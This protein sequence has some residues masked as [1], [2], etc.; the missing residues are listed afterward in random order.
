MVENSIELLQSQL[1]WYSY[2]VSFCLWDMTYFFYQAFLF[3]TDWFDPFLLSDPFGGIYTWSWRKRSYSGIHVKQR[4]LCP[5][6]GH[7]LQLVSQWF[8]FCKKWS[9]VITF[10]YSS[11]VLIFFHRSR[12]VL[13]LENSEIGVL[14]HFLLYISHFS[15]VW[16]IEKSAIVL[17]ILL[18]KS[19][20]VWVI[21]QMVYSISKGR[22][23][24]SMYE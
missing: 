11:S 14:V 21:F 18:L 9:S 12:M 16:G 5:L 24:I 22:V 1:H 7:T 3:S 4:L 13:I 15:F 17:S 20:T 2:S 6:R 8:Y 23:Y 19:C 10:L